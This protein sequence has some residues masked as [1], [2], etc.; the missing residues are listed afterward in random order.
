MA[1][2]PYTGFV[3]IAREN[4]DGGNVKVYVYTDVP[5]GSPIPPG[6]KVLS[7]VEQALFNGLDTTK[8]PKDIFFD[9]NFPTRAA[10]KTAFGQLVDLVM[11]D[12][13]AS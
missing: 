1:N 8:N 4:Q 11:P 2:P 13:A 6:G 5:E 3:L 9:R 7:N 10:F 12:T